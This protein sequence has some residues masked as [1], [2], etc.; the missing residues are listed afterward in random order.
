MSEQTVVY[1]LKENLYRE[2]CP[3]LLLG[4]AML[5]SMEFAPSEDGTISEKKMQRIVLRFRSIDPRPLASVYVDIHAFDV[6][7]REVEV[8]REKRYLLPF[9]HRDEEFGAEESIP[10]VESAVSFSVA[11]RRV[12]FEGD[13]QWNGSGSILFENLPPI[14]TIEEKLEDAK[15]LEQFRRDFNGHISENGRGQAAFVP[16][17]YKDLWFCACGEINRADEEQ[18]FACGAAYAPQHELIEDEEQI[19]KNLEAHEK[20]VA[21]QAE[22]ERLE[23][24]RRAAEEKAAAEERARL[25][26]EEQA[27]AEARARRRKRRIKIFF[28][29][30]IPLVAAAVVFAYIYINIM[31][32]QQNY[33]NAVAMLENGEYDEAEAAFALM[34]EENYED[35]YTRL[36]EIEYLRGEELMKSGDWEDAITRFEASNGYP[37]AAEGIEEANYQLA[38]AVMESGDYAGALEAFEPLGDYKDLAERTELCYYHLTMDALENGKL[39]EALANRGELNEEHL[40]ELEQAIGLKGIAFYK[41]EQ[42]DRAEEYFQY[43][44]DEKLRAQYTAAHYDRAIQ[45]LTDGKYDE[46]M[47]LFIELGE[48]EDCAERILEIHYLKGVQYAAE[49]EYALALEELTAAGDYSDAK[50]RFVAISY[51]YGVA[52]LNAERAVDA[53]N[54]LYPIRNYYDAYKLLITKSLFY[55]YVYDPGRGPNPMNEDI[56]FVG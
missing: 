31:L 4:G 56:T 30:S 47:A 40:A 48:Y 27:A 52:L 33:D 36:K 11:I 19:K 18:C 6:L 12:D 23:A 34:A 39:D 35:S 32:P 26:A 15:L 13:E 53:Y 46:A 10:V 50:E 55:R 29:I 42:D 22:K 43:V 38:V 14:Q 21:E 16:G 2:G 17:E 49:G 37:G 44:K 20:A 54:V 25:A 51:D 45:R 28:A 41:E 3:V 7:N 24:E 9:L 5:Q 8:V 1:E